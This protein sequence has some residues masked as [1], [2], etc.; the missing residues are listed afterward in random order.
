M[1][2]FSVRRTA[3]PGNLLHS[4]NKGFAVYDGER[5]ITVIFG[6][7]KIATDHM[8]RIAQL[9]DKYGWKPIEPPNP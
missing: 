1:T 9:Y 6:N 2:R 4:L 8:H 3:L 7:H 5:R